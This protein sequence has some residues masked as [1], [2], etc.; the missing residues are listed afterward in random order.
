MH[1]PLL[2]YLNYKIS[3]HETLFSY[4]LDRHSSIMERKGSIHSFPYIL[5]DMQCPITV[6]RREYNNSEFIFARRI[7]LCNHLKVWVKTWSSLPLAGPYI[8]Y[9]DQ[10]LQFVNWA[11]EVPVFNKLTKL[12]V[13][14]GDLILLDFTMKEGWMHYSPLNVKICCFAQ[15]RFVSK[16]LYQINRWGKRKYELRE[17]SQIQKLLRALS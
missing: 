14:K 7:T 15:E 9:Y 8:N 10:F 1:K 13:M 11:K 3:H 6:R 17:F 16:D 5:T 2:V 12:E 4:R